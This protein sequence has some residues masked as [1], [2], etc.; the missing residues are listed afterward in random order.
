[1]SGSDDCKASHLLANFVTPRQTDR[2][3]RRSSS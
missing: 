2:Q 3:I 1:M